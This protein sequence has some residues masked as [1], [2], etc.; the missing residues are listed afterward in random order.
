MVILESE[1]EACNQM[2]VGMEKPS[3]SSTQAVRC[4]AHCLLK[5]LKHMQWILPKNK[6]PRRTQILGTTGKMEEVFNWELT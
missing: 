4:Q 3:I 6:I 1:Q 2:G 5:Q